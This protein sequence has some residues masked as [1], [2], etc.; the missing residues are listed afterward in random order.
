MQ[1][2]RL[3]D[4]LVHV[5]AGLAPGHKNFV[6]TC[7][8]TQWFPPGRRIRGMLNI[9]VHR[10]IK[11]FKHVNKV[12]ALAIYKTSFCPFKLIFKILKLKP[13][14]I[15][16]PAK[17]AHKGLLRCRSRR[18]NRNRRIRWSKRHCEPNRQA[19]PSP[20]PLLMLS[21]YEYSYLE[22]KKIH[23]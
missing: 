23:Q 19:I 1:S 20:P 12:V 11:R 10:P 18:S 7:W 14:K 6:R 21:A 4:D 5:M 8:R 17:A 22:P 16:S 15:C 2:Q 3:T 9:V 13:C